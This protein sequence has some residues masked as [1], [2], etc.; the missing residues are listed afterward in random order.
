MKSMRKLL[1]FVFLFVFSIILTAC[2]SSDGTTKEPTP[3]PAPSG[4]TLSFISAKYKD[5]T[6]NFDGN[7]TISYD[8]AFVFNQSDFILTATYSDNSTEVVTPTSFGI[9]NSSDDKVE[10]NYIPGSYSIK[11]SY[12]SA[13]ALL[14]FTVD[15]LDINSVTVSGINTS[16]DYT[17]DSIE[18]EVVLTYNNKT[19][20]KNTDYI[21]AYGLNRVDSGTVTISGIGLY[22]NT[23]TINFTINKLDPTAPTFTNKSFDYDGTD[24]YAEV[25]PELS[26]LS[27]VG[28]AS[29]FYNVTK[30]SEAVYEIKNK[31]TYNISVSYAVLEGY[32]EVNST[33]F[34][35]TI[36]EISIED[37]ITSEIDFTYTGSAPTEADLWGFTVT[38]NNIDLVYQTDFTV[39]LNE[40]EGI[41]NINASTTSTNASIIITGIGN[42]TGTK[43]VYFKIKPR[44]VQYLSVDI[45]YETYYAQFNI[46]DGTAKTLTINSVKF[47]DI[48]LVLNTDYTITY[49]D[50]IQAGTAYLNIN[51]IGNYNETASYDF[52]IQKKE[53]YY[54]TSSV[55]ITEGGN[56]TYDGNP[57]VCVITNLPTGVV[58][59]YE[60]YY[61]EYPE[62]GGEGTKVIVQETIEP[63]GDNYYCNYQLILSTEND[64]FGY[65]YDINYNL[66]GEY[67]YYSFIINCIAVT[68]EFNDPAAKDVDGNIHFDY[69]GSAI[70]PIIVV[71][72]YN[73]NVISSSEYVVKILEE[74]EVANEYKKVECDAINVGL[75]YI[76][77]VSKHY[78]PD[79]YRFFYIDKIDLT[80][81]QKDTIHWP[82]MVQDLYIFE[83][84][85]LDNSGSVPFIENT[86]EYR[87]YLGNDSGFDCIVLEMTNY[88][89]VIQS[90]A[91]I[92]HTYNN[93]VF[94]SFKINGVELNADEIYHNIMAYD[95][96][97][98]G[99]ICYGDYIQI[100]MNEGY[101]LTYQTNYDGQTTK[102]TSASFYAGIGD[103]NYYLSTFMIYVYEGENLL[104][105]SI[106][107]TDYTKVFDVFTID[108]ISM[109]E[110]N[111]LDSF[112][113]QDLGEIEVALK[114]GY[115]AQ[116][117]HSLDGSEEV[118]VEVGPTNSFSTYYQEGDGTGYIDIFRSGSSTPFLRVTV[119]AQSTE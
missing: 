1:V 58:A 66:S 16:Y 97:T 103:D 77:V 60:Y 20:V 104:S 83:N 95:E 12:Q 102:L 22:Q 79:G 13:G 25:C 113:S 30:N 52:I 76:E 100:V 35:V 26:S 105:Y 28:I 18:P 37:A 29:I 90:R 7:V 34:I 57:F 75:Y 115:V 3:A 5:N 39:S 40:G 99:N 36:G 81:E 53:I 64:E 80:N 6:Y 67:G 98:Y 59:S 62:G 14:V 118:L 86:D 47:G 50:N 63:I 24:R 33:S 21:I 88:K 87:F 71:K 78:S 65:R 117:S 38:V 84:K 69:T 85:R 8:E 119:T 23:R 43:I 51:G 46:Y 101:Y 107:S 82:K 109:L 49:T 114:E 70:I 92:V 54:D 93:T 31:G 72:D 106:T 10:S 15:A 44:S 42:Y 9:Y 96:P 116:Y 45:D 111:R 108:E 2:G 68:I 73:D 41:D 32:K 56:H 61:Y 48:N 110:Q 94:E 89:D 27:T 17:G 55:T 11:F 112:T 4:K 19:L 91:Y 74:T